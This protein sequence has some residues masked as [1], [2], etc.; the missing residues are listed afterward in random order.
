MPK[1]KA[2]ALDAQPA[3][4]QTP[5]TKTQRSIHTFSSVAKPKVAAN[6][7]KKRKTIHTREATPPPAP[8]AKPTTKASSKRKREAI[9]EDSDEEIVVSCK[10]PHFKA[11]QRPKVS[12]TPRAKRVK[13]AAPP[14]SQETPSKKAAALFDRLNIDSNARAIPLSLPKQKLTYDTPPETP[15][16]EIDIDLSFPRHLEDMLD[17]HAAF[18]AALSLHYS[19]NGTASP[20]ELSELLAAVTKHWKKRSVTQADIQRILAFGTNQDRAF[21]LEDCGRAGIRLSRAQP[22][23]RILKRASS[24]INEDELNTQF[25][26][27]L[28]KA[29][30]NWQSSTAKE[31]RTAAAFLAQLPLLEIT[32]NEAAARSAPLFAKGEQRLADIKAGRTAKVES[33]CA[34]SEPSTATRTPQSLQNR[35]TALLDRILAKQNAASSLPAGPTKAQ[36]E[37][38]SALQRIEDVA[39]ILSLM[40]GTKERSTFSMQVVIQQLQQSLRSPI[41]QVEVWRCLSLMSTEITPGF[42]K[43]VQSGEVQGVVVTKSGNV[44]LSELR[45]RVEHA[46]A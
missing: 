40:T 12:A 30:H 14:P 7:G 32:Q 17:M 31:N 22:R 10:A 37:R 46:C 9:A 15:V 34:T 44:D 45:A 5:S 25:E 26:N 33:K 27:A 8:L 29:W 43:V 20:V 6:E 18:L 24:Y 36:M 11:P 21:I 13:N 35:G 41:S 2:S 4:K 42:V 23:G 3:S 19:H 38:R 1:R 28:Q 39:R 16:E